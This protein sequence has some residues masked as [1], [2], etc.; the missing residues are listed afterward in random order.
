MSSRSEASRRPAAAQFTWRA[1][2]TWVKGTH[3]TSKVSG[4]FG[5]G[6]LPLLTVAAGH[7]PAQWQ[8]GEQQGGQQSGNDQAYRQFDQR[9]AG[10]PVAW[11][12]HGVA[13]SSSAAGW[14]PTE[15]RRSAKRRMA[16]APMASLASA[17]ELGSSESMARSLWQRS[18]I[19][20]YC[21]F[22]CS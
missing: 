22:S 10:L 15:P 5:L 2:N 4:F 19:I 6:E 14:A 3:S 1:T 20:V 12:G 18:A 13:P 21:S 16:S 7:L 8:Q 9:P 11:R 17:V